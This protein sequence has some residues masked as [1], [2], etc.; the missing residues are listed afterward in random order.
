[1]DINN[2]NLQYM[3]V[4]Y[5]KVFYSPFILLPG[6]DGGID[7]VLFD[8]GQNSATLDDYINAI[9]MLLGGL[10]LYILHWCCIVNTFEHVV[11]WLGPHAFFCER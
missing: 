5:N 8:D 9:L 7:G 4:I 2:N 3:Q 10:L 11:C 1:M 6:P